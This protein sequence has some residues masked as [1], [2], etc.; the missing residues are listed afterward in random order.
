MEHIQA[1]LQNK[2]SE[3]ASVSG[4]LAV[5]SAS[6]FSPVVD[7]FDL[8]LLVVTKDA[9]TMNYINHYSKDGYLI[10]ERHISQEALQQW[11]MTGENRNVIEWLIKGEI[12]M[13]RDTY[14]ESTRHRLL[15]FPKEMRS[16]KLLI[17]FSHFL[18]R[19]LQCKQYLKDGHNLDAYSSIMEALL[20]WA[21]IAIIEQG[22]HPEVTVWQQIKKINP[23]I[24]KLYEELVQST[25]TVEQ[26]AQLVL[27]ACEFNVMSKM[28]IWCELLLQVLASRNEPF[29]PYEL[30]YH[31]ELRPLHIDMALVLKKLVKRGIVREVL[32]VEGYNADLDSSQVCYTTASNL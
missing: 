31:P 2:F 21:R 7:G 25:E 20:H 24:Y 16:Q 10:Q 26:R 29:S 12:C 15:E 27:L 30:K 11:I 9:P 13:D 18:R 1:F 3:V 4:V 23:G 22:A 17:E 6:P 5:R 28:A 14:L 32:V 8:L 19:Y